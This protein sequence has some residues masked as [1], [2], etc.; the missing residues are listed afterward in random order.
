V[1]L[2]GLGGSVAANNVEADCFQY[3]LLA[4]M[5]NQLGWQEHGA[6]HNAMV[7]LRGAARSVCESW[8]VH[9]LD[10][11]ADIAV[12]GRPATGPHIL[13][14]AN[15]VEPMFV[16]VLSSSIAQ[17]MLFCCSVSRTHFKCWM[18]TGWLRCCIPV[19]RSL[20]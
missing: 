5:R 1:I 9:T 14:Y 12:A 7:K 4:C 20:P 18:S 2:E 13:A 8:G 10:E 3:A 6:L 16:G 17:P 11:F 15:A 19:P